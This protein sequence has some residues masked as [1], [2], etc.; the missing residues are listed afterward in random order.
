MTKKEVRRKGGLIIDMEPDKSFPGLCR[1]LPETRFNSPDSKKIC[2]KAPE[3][4]EEDVSNADI[5]NAINGLN[6]QF[7]KFE[8]MVN[9]NTAEII[10]VQEHV[11]SLELQCEATNDT[12]KKLNDQISAL[13]EKQEEAERYSRRWNL[14][15]LNLPEHSNEDVRKELMDIIAQII[16]EEK[17]KLGFMID[18]V[19]RVGQ[20]KDENSSRPI[21]LQ[22][23]MRTF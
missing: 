10:A 17:S 19:H 21:I 5:L 2:T 12:V 20:T 8:E 16:P 7:S 9:K 23:T 22:F 13:R 6:D 11:K 4:R 1:P 14:R 15:L 3:V 18:T